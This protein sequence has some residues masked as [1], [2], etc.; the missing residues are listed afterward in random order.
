MVNR[1]TGP[2]GRC[3]NPLSSPRVV[4]L[5]PIAMAGPSVTAG[6][7]RL[8]ELYAHALKLNPVL[9]RKA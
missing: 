3:S 7:C 8:S 4:P 5:Q 1:C 6:Q 9:L 2:M